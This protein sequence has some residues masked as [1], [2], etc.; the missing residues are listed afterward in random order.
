M[1][2]LSLF[3]HTVDVIYFFLFQ[4]LND[5]IKPPEQHEVTR[6]LIEFQ[7]LNDPIKPLDDLKRTATPN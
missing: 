5:P 1:I 7:F 3:Y 4:F 2:R 6:Y